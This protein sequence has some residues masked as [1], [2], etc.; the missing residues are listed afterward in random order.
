MT[1]PTSGSVASATGRRLRGSTSALPFHSAMQIWCSNRFKYVKAA[2]RPSGEK[3]AATARRSARQKHAALG[4][5]RAPPERESGRRDPAAHSGRPLE[6][7]D[8]VRGLE[9]DARSVGRERGERGGDQNRLHVEPIRRGE[10]VD[11]VARLLPAD[12]RKGV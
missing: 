4:V 3:A 12:R 6:E 11:R 7:L 2:L 10:A 9:R 8:A 1:R 5:P